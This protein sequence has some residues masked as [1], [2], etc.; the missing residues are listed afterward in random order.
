MED[1]YIMDP[2]PNSFTLFA[3]AGV[4]LDVGMLIAMIALLICSAFFSSVETAFTS[5][6]KIRLKN[7]AQNGNKKAELVMKLEEKYDKLIT[8]LLIGNN[9]VNIG[10]SSIATLFFI[11]IIQNND[12]AATV[13]TIVTTVV[14]LIFGEISP[15]VIARQ[16]ADKY[17]MFISRFVKIIMVVFTPFSI[18]FGGWSKLLNKVFHSK[19][20]TS[21]TED[22]LITIVDEAEEGGVI[23][24][25]EGDLIRSAIEFNDV[26]AGDILTPRVEMC[27][28]SKDASIEEIAKTFI[29]NAYSRLPVYNEDIDDI[30]GILHE[31]DFFIAYHNNNKTITKYIQKPVHV[32]EHIKIFDLLQLFK[33]KKCHMAIVVDEFGGT[34]GIVTMEDI[35]EELIGDVW[36]EHDE[37]VNDDYKELPDGSYIIKATSELDKFFEKFNI[38]VSDDDDLPQTVNGFV[39]K[40][41]E[42]FPQV[43]DS[44]EYM[45]LKIEIKKLSAKRIEEIHVTKIENEEKT[46]E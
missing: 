21:F 33:A 11:N 29:E 13:S 3:Q 46:A 41:L 44:F 16:N 43:G 1:F 12:L 38:E 23:E 10:L 5:F 9:I 22:E 30:I 35:I 15:K 7:L 39:M 20:Q 37:V 25:E 6:N 26:C 27:A 32:S 34:M 4:N 14:V 2:D 36:D 17:V 24:T 19:E 31:K 28:I 45:G 18:I 40:E 8:T 42:S